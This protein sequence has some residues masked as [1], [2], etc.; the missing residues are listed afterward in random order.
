MAITRTTYTPSD[1]F[2]AWLH[3]YKPNTVNYFSKNNVYPM[4]VCSVTG[5]HC[6]TLPG[7]N[8]DIERVDGCDRQAHT[9]ELCIVLDSHPDLRL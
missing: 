1:A 3:E 6:I 4:Q 5:R 7:T 2:I 8:S 9:R